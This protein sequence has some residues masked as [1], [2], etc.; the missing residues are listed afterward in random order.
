MASPPPVRLRLMASCQCGCGLDV[1]VA[2]RTNK[3]LGHVKGQ[4]VRFLPGHHRKGAFG[5]PEDRFRSRVDVHGPDDCWPWMGPCV[6][7]YGV[8]WRN[9]NNYGAHRMA[10][11]LANGPIPNN[12]WV[13]HRCDNP[14]CCNPSHLF[15]G[16][17][18]ENDADRTTKGRSSRGN[19][20]PDAKLNDGAVREARRRFAAG[21][22]ARDLAVE[23]G[24]SPTT[25]WQAA[26][27][28]TWKHVVD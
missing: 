26:T 3:K 27:R 18:A 2:K 4:P 6:S 21:E 16:T 8:L 12:L 5:S 22:R 10:W 14:P 23:F 15:L 1:A 17:Q 28:K 24:V 20:H 25:L 11:E 13:L 19:C 7:G 9:G